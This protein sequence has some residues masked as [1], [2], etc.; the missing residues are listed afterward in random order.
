MTDQD[1]CPAC[2]QHRLPKIPAGSFM[3][4]RI[5][6]NPACGKLFEVPKSQR[7]ALDVLDKIKT[8]PSCGKPV[9]FWD[10]FDGICAGC[11]AAIHELP[12]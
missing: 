9:D 6:Q 12:H 7:P 5:C 10:K 2:G 1:L 3:T 4:A 8:C 11:A